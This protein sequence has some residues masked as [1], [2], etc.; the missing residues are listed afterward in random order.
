MNGYTDP[1]SARRWWAI[2]L[3]VVIV[4]ETA[5]CL[6]L[7]LPQTRRLNEVRGHRRIAEQSLGAGQ[8]APETFRRS[9][10]KVAE[11]DRALER[12]RTAGEAPAQELF[13]VAIGAAAEEV[14]VE[15]LAL[16][17]VAVPEEEKKAERTLADKNS[18]DAEE[19]EDK[20]NEKDDEEEIPKPE[21]ETWRLRCAGEFSDLSAFLNAL[22]RRGV[23]LAVDN[24]RAD[25]T[26]RD[27]LEIEVLLK[28]W[29][30]PA[31][32]HVTAAART[33]GEGGSEPRRE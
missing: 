27:R 24:F 29:K 32:T 5:I 18:K 14:E 28:T 19:D 22:E 3:P 2:T 16:A 20:D 21:P 33:G 23:L 6:G 7:F 26:E 11:A 25:A 31:W 8:D 17:M 30:L 12:L 9:Q 10:D 15:I 13:M 1:P 4:A